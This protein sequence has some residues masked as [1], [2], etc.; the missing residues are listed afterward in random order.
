MAAKSDFDC[1]ACGACCCNPEEN[2]EIDFI[3]YVEIDPTDRILKQPDLVRRLVVLDS[4]FVPHMRLSQYQ[5]CAAL[6]GRVGDKVGCAIYEHR[7]SS[8]AAF[9]AGSDDCLLARR[10][11][12]IDPWPDA[13]LKK[14][15]AASGARDRK[16]EA[17]R[18]ASPRGGSDPRRRTRRA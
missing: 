13:N 7:P 18:R 15:R 6:T 10:E 4:K 17:A 11:R 3:D 1:V 8:C 16:R 9:E 2:R 12:G 14:K 5:R